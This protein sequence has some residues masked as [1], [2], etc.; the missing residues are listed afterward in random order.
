MYAIDKYLLKIEIHNNLS[1]EI[2]KVHKTQADEN[3][4]KFMNLS[5][6]SK[7]SQIFINNEWHRS[8]S[9]KTFET[10]NPTT[11]QKIADIQYAGK[12][13]VDLA[14]IAARNAFKWV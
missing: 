4:I 9:G 11:E 7:N 2:K 3:E 14:V 13:D 8:K 10:L 5:F 12:E 1:S 6:F